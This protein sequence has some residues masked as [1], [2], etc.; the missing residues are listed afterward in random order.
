MKIFITGATG[1]VGQHL[2][3]RLIKN[4]SHRI[5]CLVRKGS[6]GRSELE[7]LGVST[8][9]GDLSNQIFLE[10][11]LLD[12][13][14][15]YH[16][17]GSVFSKD[18]A[19]IYRTNVEGSETLYRA[20][21]NT[22]VKR[23]IFLSSMAAV[24][25]SKNK[26]PV[27]ETQRPSPLSFYGRSKR[28][29]EMRLKELWGEIKKPICVIRC[30]LIYGVGMSLESRLFAVADRLKRGQ[31]KLIGRGGNKISLCQ[32][33][34]LVDFLV[35][36]PNLSSVEYEV[37][38]IA[39]LGSFEL[40]ELVAKMAQYINSQAELTKIPK[41]VAMGVAALL[42]GIR[43]FSPIAS[44]LTLEH[45][46]ELSNDWIVSIDKAMRYGYSPRKD[47]ESKLKETL[48]WYLSEG[49]RNK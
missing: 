29:A 7:K 44:D 4:S 41:V 10:K 25:C 19:E 16:L 48:S 35:S 2:V 45:V 39:D 12:A 34:N 14:V 28:L 21:H 43:I 8:L 22:S 6:S 9:C 15:V 33:D 1:F 11:E 13:D 47:W 49:L 32:I 40:R 5:T 27:T 30:P 20:L 18:K 24:G 17:A 23:F 38:H 31:L 42:D 46:R 26:Q 37:F 3:R 36:I